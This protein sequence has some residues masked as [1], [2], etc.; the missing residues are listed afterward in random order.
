VWWLSGEE[1]KNMTP[2]DVIA[3]LGLQP[4]LMEG[5]WFCETYRSTARI[6]DKSL[7]TAIYYL[8]TPTSFSRLHRLPSDE[9]FHFYLGD[10]VEQLQL[11]PDG[12]GQVVTLG[13]DLAAGQRPQALVSAGVW[14]GSRL[15]PGGRFA[16]LGTTMSPGFE[17]ADYED[18]D[19]DQ[20]SVAYPTWRSQ[21]VE[22]TT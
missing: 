13:A 10:P 9:L 16:L 14:Q 1:R 22:L 4:L 8:I 18:G 5:G 21:I 15:M 6:G 3:A 12:A 20:L 17:F 19:R 7:A 11:F 2:E